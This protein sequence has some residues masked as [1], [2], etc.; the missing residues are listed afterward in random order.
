MRRTHLPLNG[1]RVLDAAARHL[2]FT[3][4]AKGANWPFGLMIADFPS[5]RLFTLA[6]AI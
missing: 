3:R 5:E 4:A 2:S 1:L 6:Y